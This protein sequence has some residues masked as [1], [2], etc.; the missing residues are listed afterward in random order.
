MSSIWFVPRLCNEEQLLLRESLE[1][2]VRRIGS[3]CEMVASLEV[4]GV[5]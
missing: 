2:A 1:M 3:W 5:E 4:N